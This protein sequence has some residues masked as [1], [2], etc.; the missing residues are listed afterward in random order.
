MNYLIEQPIKTRKAELS[1]LFTNWEDDII[2]KTG[3]SYWAKKNG[4]TWTS[5]QFTTMDTRAGLLYL[6]VKRGNVIVSEDIPH[7]ID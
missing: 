7:S 4:D 5:E 1:D 6:E 3:I 2:I